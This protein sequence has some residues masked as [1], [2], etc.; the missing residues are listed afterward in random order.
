VD[1]TIT[2][3]PVYTDSGRANAILFWQQHIGLPSETS[4]WQPQNAYHI[5][6][7]HQMYHLEWDGGRATVEST[8]QPL[9]NPDLTGS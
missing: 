2:T 6:A 9:Y 7:S 4:T 3:T 5:Q 8:S 1:R